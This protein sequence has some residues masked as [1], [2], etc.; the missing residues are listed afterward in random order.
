MT[1]TD[2]AAVYTA[3]TPIAYQIVVTNNG[4]SHADGFA[5]DDLVPATITG[6]TVN[7]SVTSGMGACGTNSTSGNSVV[8]RREPERGQLADAHVTGTINPSATG[9]IVN[10]ATVAGGGG[11][12]DPTANN[13]SATDTDTATAQAIELIVT[14]DNGQASYVP[15]TPVTYTVTVT[16]GGP[17]T[18]TGFSIADAVPASIT[19]LTV[20]CAATG[21]ELVR[22][23]HAR[24][25]RALQ[26]PL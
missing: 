19:G 5:I 17:S 24:S 12:T 6:V 26:R 3:G 7:C 21:S 22:Q 25:V 23:R 1:K 9:D 15:G 8:S 2:G 18:A 20:K 4:P 14:N 16:N 11:F 10:T 13:D